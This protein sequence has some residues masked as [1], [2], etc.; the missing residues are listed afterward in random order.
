MDPAAAEHG[1]DDLDLREVFEIAVEGVAVEDDEVGEVAGQEL[2]A[3]SL[4]ALEPGRVDARR[5]Q[6]LLDAQRLLGVP[7]EAAVV[8]A[9]HAGADAGERVEL[10]DRGVG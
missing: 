9:E 8:R 6:G 1:G 10:L 2:A 5:V 3:S 4:G 7:G